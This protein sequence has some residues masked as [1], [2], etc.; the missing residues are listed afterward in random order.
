[1]TVLEYWKECLAHAA[2][3]GG[4]TLT[5]EQLSQLAEGCVGG[6][7]N[8][9]MAFYSPPPS[10]RLNE[11]DRAWK[12][13]YEALEKEFETYR[14]GAETAIKRALPK[15]TY[16]DSNVGITNEGEVFVYGGRVTQIL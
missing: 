15:R 4:F 7:E 13:K 3:E 1:M 11:I 2:D 16:P 5:D 14:H 6:H 12:A 8:Y 9:G 10:D